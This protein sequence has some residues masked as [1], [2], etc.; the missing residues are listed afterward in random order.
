MF[1]ALLSCLLCIVVVAPP[2]SQASCAPSDVGASRV[3]SPSDSDYDDARDQWGALLGS[4]EETEFRLAPDMIVYPADENEVLSTIAFAKACGYKLSVR[5]GGHQY[6]AYSSCKENAQCI[7]VSMEA[8]N[9]LSDPFPMGSDMVATLGV[10]N[11]LSD[12]IAKYA[13]LGYHLTSGVCTTV[14]VGGHYQSSAM[15]YLTKVEGL[16]IDAVVSFRIA[17]ADGTIQDVVEGDEL[18]WAALGGSPGSWGIVLDYTVKLVPDNRYNTHMFRQLWVYSAENFKAI[19]DAWAATAAADTDNVLSMGLYVID[20]D[21]LPLGLPFQRALMVTGVYVGAQF[22]SNFWD[23]FT[24]SAAGPFI[25]GVFTVPALNAP[26]SVLWPFLAGDYNP[27]N[28]RYLE[29]SFSTDDYAK[30]DDDFTTLYVQEVEDRIQKG[31]KPDLQFW[32]ITGGVMEENDGKNAYGYRKIKLFVDDWT[33]FTDGSQD[34]TDA[35]VE[36]YDAFSSRLRSY[37]IKGRTPDESWMSTDPTVADDVTLDEVWKDYY[38]SR[39]W[40]HRC[41]AIKTEVDPDDIF[42]H[43]MTMPLSPGNGKRN[44]N[45][46]N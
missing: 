21:V 20:Q 33:F 34:N 2:P 13:P 27:N 8:F 7:Q 25:P 18:Y 22:P 3:V 4:L 26:M 28:L 14:G 44:G 6:S 16:G 45:S 46:G 31:W 30:W 38:P 32:A 9:S 23:A 17:L 29:K 37:S 43:P 5:S 11:R 41:K 1:V 35:I 12:L 39:Q 42:S 19:L 24:N 15:G 10:G 36:Q 40:F